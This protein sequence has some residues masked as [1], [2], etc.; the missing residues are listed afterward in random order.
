MPSWPSVMLEGC[1]VPADRG[2]LLISS[3]RPP[4]STAWSSTSMYAAERTSRS[5]TTVRTVG[6]APAKSSC[7]TAAAASYSSRP[8]T[9]MFSLTRVTSAGPSPAP[10]RIVSTFSY[11]VRAC[12]SIGPPTVSLPSEASSAAEVWPDVHAARPSASPRQ[13]VNPS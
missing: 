11:A 4:P 5:T 9:V 8:R 3:W 2:S 6:P 1:Q 12:C 13:N 10:P 7:R